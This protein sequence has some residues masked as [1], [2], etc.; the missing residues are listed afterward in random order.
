[1]GVSQNGGGGSLW[2]SLYEGFE[3]FEVEIGGP[4][5]KATTISCHNPQ[6]RPESVHTKAGGRTMAMLIE[7][8]AKTHPKPLTP[9]PKLLNS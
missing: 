9:N 8:I 2:G 3:Y 7:V 1:M 5:F 6:Y 4:R